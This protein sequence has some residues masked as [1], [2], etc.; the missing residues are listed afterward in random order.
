[1]DT[2]LS[3]EAQD[4][5]DDRT[6]EQFFPAG[7]RGQAQDQAGDMA[8]VSFVDQRA[9]HILPADLNNDGPQVLGEAREIAEE[10]LAFSARLASVQ[11]VAQKKKRYV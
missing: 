6:G 7:A 5:V 8:R 1:M 11:A 4:A 10:I 2:H 3:G 9:R